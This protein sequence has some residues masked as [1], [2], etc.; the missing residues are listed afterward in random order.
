MADSSADSTFSLSNGSVF[1]GRRLN[2]TFPRSIVIPSTWSLSASGY[3]AST[4]LMAASGSETTKL[5]SPE[6]RVRLHLPTQGG[7]R[8]ARF[9]DHA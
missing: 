3:I 9:G 4:R 1:D 2:Q 6:A 7:E 8:S 5:I